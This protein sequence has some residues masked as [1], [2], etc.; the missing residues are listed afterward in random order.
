MKAISML[1]VASCLTMQEPTPEEKEAKFLD[2]LKTTW[3][4]TCIACGGSGKLKYDLDETIKGVQIDCEFC[5]A[6]KRAKEKKTEVGFWRAKAY[7]EAAGK[8]GDTVD[9]KLLGWSV[10]VGRVKELKVGSVRFEGE[11][12]LTSLQALVIGQFEVINRLKVDEL[13]GFIAMA[14]GERKFTGAWLILPKK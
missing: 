11:G 2:A 14:V 9:P 8:Q 5:E 1:L 7:S 10:V 6:R 4:K 3:E 12:S 13:V